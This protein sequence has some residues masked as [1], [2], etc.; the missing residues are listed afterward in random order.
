MPLMEF[1]LNDDL[2]VFFTL[3]ATWEGALPNLLMRE[4]C[5]LSMAMTF[6]LSLG[7]SP[8]KMLFLSLLSS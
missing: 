4:R 2:G 1:C 3:L 7:S 8:M 5:L 6:S